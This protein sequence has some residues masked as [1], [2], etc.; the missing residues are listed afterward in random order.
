M[1]F[2]FFFF[3]S[4]DLFQAKFYSIS[5]LHIKILVFCAVIINMSWA[6]LC[7]LRTADFN[8]VLY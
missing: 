6:C 5:F 3:F 7:F 1:N 2:L 4:V 8:D